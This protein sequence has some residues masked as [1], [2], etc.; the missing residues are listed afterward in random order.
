M[1]NSFLKLILG[2]VIIWGLWGAGFFGGKLT[3]RDKIK[4]QILNCQHAPTPIQIGDS[5]YIIRY[6]PLNY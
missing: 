6:Y 1:E 4:S 3:E 5:T 2:L